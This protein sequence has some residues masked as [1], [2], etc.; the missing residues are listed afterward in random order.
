MKMMLEDKNVL[1]TGGSRGIG[2]A[3]ALAA[4]AAGA[5]VAIAYASAEGPALEVVAQIKLL[6]RNA[7]AIK[8]DVS[9]FAQAGAVVAQA[10]EAL[11][12]LD[13]VVNNAGVT[14]DKLAIALSEDDWDTVLDTNLKGAFAVS[15]AAAKHMAKRRYGRI[16]NISSVS[17][18]TGNAGQANYAAAKAGLV[19]M[20]KTFAKELAGRN[21]TVN[22]VAPGFIA[23]DMTDALSDKIKESV[24]PYIPLKRFG[25][26]E[27]IAHAVLFLASDYANYITGA[28]LVVDGGMTM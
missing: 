1:V 14:R 8:S 21:I 15:Q 26:P 3:I 27:D 18:I 24:L 11:G 9:D 20:T 16:I 4:A 13:V 6:G 7:V 23:T 5:N 28:T 12:H 10:V 25:Q 2:K 17:G 19:G 22:A